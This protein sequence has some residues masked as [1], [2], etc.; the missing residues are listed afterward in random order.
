M[1]ARLSESDA[2]HQYLLDEYDHI[3]QAH[4][5]T[6]DT[7][8][9]F[10]KHYLLIMSVPISVG[11]ALLSSSRNANALALVAVGP[12]VLVLVAV[13]GLL[14]FL[15]IVNLR[16]DAILYARTINALRKF[17]YDRLDVSE[18]TARETC[19]LPRTRSQ[20]EYLERAYFYP[21][22]SAFALLDGAYCGAAAALV[23]SQ[24]TPDVRGAAQVLVPPT[25]VLWGVAAALMFA[26]VHFWLYSLYA[27]HREKDYLRGE[28]S[29]WM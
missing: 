6:M 15:Y 22:V 21:V 20:P 8:S 5:K 12:W 3:A 17:F 24:V 7:L 1:P 9:A 10:F 26:A 28:A 13:L 11:V 27:E 16:M 19:V 2:S 25:A 18:E 4:F 29:E 14:L 23:L